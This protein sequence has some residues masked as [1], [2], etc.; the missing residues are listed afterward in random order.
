MAYSWA[1][2]RKEILKVLTPFQ[3]PPHRYHP[4]ISGAYILS[5][6][7]NVIFPRLTT[8]V[9]RMPKCTPSLFF[10]FSLLVPFC[11]QPSVRTVRSFRV[12][13]FLS[14]FFH[15]SVLR[16]VSS[17]TCGFALSLISLTIDRHGVVK[18][19]C[20]D[21]FECVVLPFPHQEANGRVHRHI[22]NSFLLLAIVFRT[23]FT[24]RPCGTER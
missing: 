8:Q 1:S 5:E 16:T 9:A 10:L 22:R 7:I 11:L 2:S 14:I 6:P 15:N 19:T 4:Q 20:R 24:R 12:M 3:P 18:A 23:S 17:Q 13:P 21:A